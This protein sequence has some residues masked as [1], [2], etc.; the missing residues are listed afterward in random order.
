MYE[1][2]NDLNSSQFNSSD[3]KF[4][5]NGKNASQTEA[6]KLRIELFLSFGKV[7]FD[8]MRFICLNSDVKPGSLTYYFVRSKELIMTSLKNR[9]VQEKIDNMETGSTSEVK[10][11]R[12]KARRFVDEGK[13]D[14]EGKVT[15]FG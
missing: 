1:S 14:L 12:Q 6:T 10:M 7:F 4:M 3:L 2:A 5:Q 13:V 15:I 9:V 11:K 8:G